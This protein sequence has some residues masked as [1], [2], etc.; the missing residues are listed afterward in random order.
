MLETVF[1]RRRKARSRARLSEDAAEPP[2]PNVRTVRPVFEVEFIEPCVARDC[3]RA[4]E[5]VSRCS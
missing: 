4:T 5:R 1:G 2:E 3:V